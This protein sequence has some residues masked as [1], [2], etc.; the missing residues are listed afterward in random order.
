MTLSWS[1]GRAWQR[2]AGVCELRVSGWVA[3]RAERPGVGALWAAAVQTVRLRQG[4][5][6][7]G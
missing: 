6:G 7:H 5:L 2:N 4:R 3:Y 1:T